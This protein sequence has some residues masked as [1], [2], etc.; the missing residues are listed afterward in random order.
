[1]KVEVASLSVVAQHHLFDS[2]ALLRNKSC[3]HVNRIPSSTGPAHHV[4]AHHR[5]RKLTNSL[6]L[7]PRHHLSLSLNLQHLRRLSDVLSTPTGVVQRL[8]HRHLLPITQITPIPLP[9]A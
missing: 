3:Q 9:T 7:F 8:R 4:V 6:S 2:P 1:M 5:R